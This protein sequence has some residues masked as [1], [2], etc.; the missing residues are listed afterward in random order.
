MTPL[1]RIFN[2][3]GLIS[4]LVFNTD[5]G[6]QFITKD[7]TEAEGYC[8]QEAF[9]GVVCLTG[10]GWLAVYEVRNG[11]LFETT[12]WDTRYRDDDFRK[13]HIVEVSTA[14]QN[15]HEGVKEHKPPCSE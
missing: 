8:L 12:M 15:I 2:R 11:D 14:V 13:V 9:Y 5:T 10:R 6:D 3:D 4:C 1:E 7:L